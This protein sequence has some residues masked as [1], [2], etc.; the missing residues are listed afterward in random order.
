MEIN[1]KEVKAI[2][3]MTEEEKDKYIGCDNYFHYGNSIFCIELD[4]GSIVF[5]TFT[6]IK[7]MS[8]EK[9]LINLIP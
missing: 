7:C 6:C 4:D 3:P 1:S 9:C 5:P 8:N 2:R